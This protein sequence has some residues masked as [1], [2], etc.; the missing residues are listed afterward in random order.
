MYK[1]ENFLKQRDTISL[2]DPDVYKLVQ[3]LVHDGI[4]RYLRE[5]IY[6]HISGI[7]NH[8]AVVWRCLITLGCRGFFEEGC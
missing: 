6:M 7:A 5:S 2:E 1:W 8:F 4:P 3:Q